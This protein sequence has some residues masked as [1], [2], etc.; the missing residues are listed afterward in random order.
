M[1]SAR[2]K[3]YE[4]SSREHAERAIG[5]R[6]R[7]WLG[8]CL[9]GMMVFV[10]GAVV[11]Q[12][13]APG[14][15][16][17][18]EDEA[19]AQQPGELTPPDAVNKIRCP[20]RE[21][22]KKRMKGIADIRVTDLPK[23]EGKVFPQDC[24]KEL[25]E[26]EGEPTMTLADSRGWPEGT[27]SWKASGAVHRPLYFEDVTLERYGHTSAIPGLQ[28]VVSGVRFYGQ[29][30]MLPY[31]MGIDRPRKCIYTL[32]YYRPGDCVPFQRQTF[33]IQLNAAALE[34]GT[35]AGLILLIP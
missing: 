35:I 5:A 29:L 6:V 30:A 13:P 11:A 16:L 10:A 3:R 9:T 8:L 12:E 25:I 7:P 33:P 4:T 20:T 21:D 1:K 15:R 2:T 31:Q 22:L 34:V 18:D 26:E 28:P 32:G 17:V 23:Q 27:F 24:A 19:I 14:P